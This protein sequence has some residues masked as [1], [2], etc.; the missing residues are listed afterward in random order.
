MCLPHPLILCHAACGARTLRWGLAGIPALE[1]SDLGTGGGVGQLGSPRGEGP[2]MVLKCGSEG[3]RREGWGGAGSSFPEVFF[4]VL[5]VT[6][7]SRGP[8]LRPECGWWPPVV[9]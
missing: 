3:C 5:R 6:P 7:Q 2:C 1:Q 8:C 9:G 4:T